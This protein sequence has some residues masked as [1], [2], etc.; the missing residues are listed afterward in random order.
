MSLCYYCTMVSGRVFFFFVLLPGR[1]W[2]HSN[3]GGDTY[4]MSIF[5]ADD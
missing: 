1:F 3:G 5:C 2:I 4:S